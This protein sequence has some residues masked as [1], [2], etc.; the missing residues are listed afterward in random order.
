MRNNITTF[1]VLK[2]HCLSF[3][4]DKITKFFCFFLHL[5]PLARYHE[6]VVSQFLERVTSIIDESLLSLMFVKFLKWRSKL[7]LCGVSGNWQSSRS[8]KKKIYSP[9]KTLVVPR[10]GSCAI[11]FG[12]F[13]LLYWTKSSDKGSVESMR[14]PCRMDTWSGS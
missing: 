13:I 4:V 10:E 1:R 6:L 9:S 3:K 5:Q 14:D 7:G 8:K 2:T 12:V 11:K